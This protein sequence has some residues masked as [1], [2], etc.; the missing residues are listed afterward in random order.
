[1]LRSIRVGIILGAV[2]A[3][4][5]GSGT[6][7]QSAHVGTAGGTV[8]TDNVRLDVPS[9]A[10]QSDTQI[11]V[12]EVT[13]PGGT[14]RRVQID[15]QG[16]ALAQTAR[17]SIKDNGSDVPVKLV[18]VVGQNERE[19]GRCCH[20]MTW[21]EHSGDVTQFGTV[22][23]VQ[24]KTC[25]P[26]CPTG[27]YCDDGVC[28]TPDAFCSYCGQACGPSGCDGW[29]CGCNGGMCGCHLD[30]GTC[31]SGSNCCDGPMCC[32]GGMCGMH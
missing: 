29:M 31:C 27:Q 22:D 24:G 10:L 32:M 3:V 20:D 14:I 9:G 15:P 11:T 2:S 4:A 17:I 13:P 25:N 21:H 5:C 30:G 19:L 26:A 18:G 8:S 6:N 1:M 28:T 23:L 7:A 12:R 16:L